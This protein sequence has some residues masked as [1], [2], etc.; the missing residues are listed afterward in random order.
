MEKCSRSEAKSFDEIITDDILER[1]ML[2][3]SRISDY[4]F[5]KKFLRKFYTS[6]NDPQRQS[7]FYTKTRDFVAFFLSKNAT[8]EY[9]NTTSWKLKKKSSH[10]LDIF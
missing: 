9:T 7:E 6:K 5:D 8:K 10:L 3:Y 1:G 2:F 4:N